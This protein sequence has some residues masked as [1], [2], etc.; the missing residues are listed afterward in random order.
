MSITITTADDQTIEVS[1]DDILARMNG[2]A[3]E[4]IVFVDTT[5]YEFIVAVVDATGHADAQ[6]VSVHADYADALLDAASLCSIEVRD[7][8]SR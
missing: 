5:V 8:M 4:Y 3:T 6:L 1:S 2:V 7:E